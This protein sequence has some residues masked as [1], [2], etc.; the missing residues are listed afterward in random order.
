MWSI[1]S[2]QRSHEIQWRKDCLFNKQYWKNQSAI[3]KRMKL[4]HYL[5]PYTKLTNNRIKDL[6]EK[7]ETIK[8]IEE[9]LD[10]KLFDID[11]G[12]DFTNLTPKEKA[13]KAK[14]NGMT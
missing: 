3:C 4:N 1:N 8:L 9:N 14:I 6:N 13:T 11:L 10:S 2:Q 7:L 12:S 5:I